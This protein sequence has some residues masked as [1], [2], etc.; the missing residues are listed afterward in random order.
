MASNGGSVLNST[1][2]HSEMMYD[3]EFKNSPAYRE[4][5]RVKHD[6]T[7]EDLDVQVY[8]VDKSV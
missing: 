2:K 7:V 5:K 6:H 3:L 8:N 1:L 4:A